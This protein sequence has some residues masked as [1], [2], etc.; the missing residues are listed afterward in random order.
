[1]S[2]SPG[3]ISLRCLRLLLLFPACLKRVCMSLP[4]IFLFLT[5]LLEP[6]MI[7]LW[8]ILCLG[9]LRPARLAPSAICLGLPRFVILLT[10]KSLFGGLVI[11]ATTRSFSMKIFPVR[12]INAFVT[13]RLLIKSRR[14]IFL[15][16]PKF[17]PL[18]L[19]ENGLLWANFSATGL[20][21][22]VG[23]EFILWISTLRMTNKGWFALFAMRPL[24]LGIRFPQ[25]HV[26]KM[27][28][29]RLKPFPA[30]R[31]GNFGPLGIPKLRNMPRN[32]FNSAPKT[33]LRLCLR[34]TK[35]LMIPDGQLNRRNL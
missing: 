32:T 9:V 7:F 5:L 1:M 12:I 27:L 25:T 18:H 17:Q 30:L 34:S 33:W 6:L 14:L 2:R 35:L 26:P 21:N 24:P 13:C 15:P 16:F 29:V 8:P 28:R 3:L 20:K 22:K 19:L 4:R 10:P 11:N 23:T 31:N